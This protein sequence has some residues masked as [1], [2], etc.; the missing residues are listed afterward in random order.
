MG[1]IMSDCIDTV[2]SLMPSSSSFKGSD[3]E[4]ILDQTI[5][6]YF[7]SKEND[8]EELLNAPFLT[9]AT[10]DYLDLLYG[11]LY[12]VKRDF[13]ES[14]D[15]YRTRL[16]FQARD[17]V[18]QSDLQELGCNVYAY[19]DDF[20]AEYTLT[21]RNT[22]LTQKVLVEFPSLEVE[23]LVKNNLLW[24]KLLVSV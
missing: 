4:A 8:I 20:D 23:E 2:T 10:G 14:D 3:V 12:G 13:D 18:R 9:E 15:D 22:S 11:K 6:P 1:G 7:D 24:E 16:T 19:V 5:G 17:K 21:S